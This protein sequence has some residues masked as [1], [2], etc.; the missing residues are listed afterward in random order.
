MF[1]FSA[2]A[3][4]PFG[5]GKAF[6]SHLPAAL[7]YVVGGWQ[8]NTIDSLHTGTPFDVTT[9]NYFYT[10][11]TGATSQPS[12]SLNNRADIVKPVHYIKSLNEWFDVSGFVRPP[13]INPNGQTSTYSRVGT[14]GRNQMFGPGYED[15]DLSLFKSVPLTERVMGQFRAEAYNLTNTPAFTNPNGNIDNCTGAAVNACAS[16]PL[17]TDT[18]S[19]GQIHGTRTHSERQIQLAFRLE[20]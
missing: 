14:L 13:V 5:K 15:M 3:E 8:A 7:N 17:L 19:Y 16:N 6:A 11:A 10:S 12:A 18:G 9:S 20:F 1:V 4:L 2:L